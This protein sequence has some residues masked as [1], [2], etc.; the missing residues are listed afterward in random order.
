MRDGGTGGDIRVRGDI[1]VMMEV[2]F[3][4]PVRGRH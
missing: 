3:V 4:M 2:E 1:R